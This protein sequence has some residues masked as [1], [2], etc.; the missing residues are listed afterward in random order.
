MAAFEDPNAFGQ[1]WMVR[2]DEPM[3]FRTVRAPQYPAKCILPSFVTKVGRRRLG[4][5]IARAADEKA[6]TH[7]KDNKQ[8]MAACVFDVMAAGDFDIAQAGAY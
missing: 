5:S 2:N 1:E 3:L 8:R 6:C 4:E 7:L